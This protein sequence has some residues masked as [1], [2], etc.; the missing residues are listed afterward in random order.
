[1][2]YFV[3]L[4]GFTIMPIFD[5]SLFVTIRKRLNHESLDKMVVTLV[6]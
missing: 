1:M 3:G 2:Q 4:R 5:S 6:K